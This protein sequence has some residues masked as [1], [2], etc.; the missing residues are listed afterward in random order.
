MFK[1]L[2]CGALIATSLICGV[3]CAGSEHAIENTTTIQ[4]E[5]MVASEIQTACFFSKSYEIAKDINTWLKEHPNVNI[6]D[7]KFSAYS[8]DSFVTALIIFQE[9]NMN[10]EIE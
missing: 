4:V 10:E 2:I 5:P 9:V 8:K 3:G 6:I 1:K 7:I